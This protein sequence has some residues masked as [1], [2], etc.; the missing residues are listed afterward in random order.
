MNNEDVVKEFLTRAYINLCYASFAAEGKNGIRKDYKENLD[1]LTNILIKNN[2]S[3]DLFG[4]C[5]N[6]ID[7]LAACITNISFK[8]NANLQR[9]NLERYLSTETKIYGKDKPHIPGLNELKFDKMPSDEKIKET[10]GNLLGNNQ[11]HKSKENE[12]YDPPIGDIDFEYE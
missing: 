9:K 12:K 8:E 4:C 2:S 6:G 1:E 11:C 3:D 5:L 7:A 10:L